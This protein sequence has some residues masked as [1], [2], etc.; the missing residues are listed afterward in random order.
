MGRDRIKHPLIVILLASDYYLLC[1]FEILVG[2]I[3]C[4]LGPRFFQESSAQIVSWGDGPAFSAC[5][6]F[7]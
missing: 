2:L 6:V 1:D 3:N 7:I 5:C 4:N